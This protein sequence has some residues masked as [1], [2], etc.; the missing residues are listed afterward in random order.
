MTIAWQA[1][2]IQAVT[3]R[4]PCLMYS[5]VVNPRYAIGVYQ[6]VCVGSKVLGIPNFRNILSQLKGRWCAK[7]DNQ[8]VHSI[9]VIV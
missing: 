3:R 4:Y 8:D 9:K 1:Y 5:G 2:T 6:N 7:R